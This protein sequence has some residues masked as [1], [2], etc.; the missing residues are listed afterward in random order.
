MLNQL[1]DRARRE[2]RGLGLG[3]TLR[4]LSA[5][6]AGKIAFSTSFGQE[7]QV[8]AHLIFSGQH[9]I[10]VFTLDTGRLFQETYDVWAATL[11]RYGQ[12]S[13]RNRIETWFPDRAEVQE[14]LSEGGPNSFYNSVDERKRCCHVRKVVPL[15]KALQGVEIWITGLRAGQSSGRNDTE[16]FEVDEKFGLVKYNP[17]W[18]WSLAQ[19]EEFL[20]E[21]A[22]PQNRLHSQ[23]FL[24]IGC[25]PCTRAVKP[26][27]DI[28]A[29]RW[30]WEDESK[31][32]GLHA[33]YLNPQNA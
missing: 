20:R 16:A 12:E 18:D 17:L 4:W 29:G 25:A 5:H 26:G 1:I 32:C 21:N 7:D 23:G 10:R 22:V 6:H 27:E 11:A 28:R 31:E 8:I 19:V 13:D 2:T 30:W 3:E 24:S 9:P 33:N 15:Q 14:L